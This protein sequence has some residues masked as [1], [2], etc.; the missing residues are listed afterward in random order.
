MLLSF[1]RTVECRTRN[2]GFIASG[3]G[4]GQ[5]GSDDALRAFLQALGLSG[6]LAPLGA[7]RPSHTAAT[8]PLP[9]LHRQFDQIV[10][11]TQ[12]LI[13]KSPDVRKDFWK[14]ADA[15]SIAAWKE[16][17][18]FYRDYIWD[19]VIGRMPPPALPPTPVPG[20]FS[21]SRISRDMK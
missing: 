10:D 4:H 12:A 2:S 7:T 9:R 19:E 15:S 5:P 13:R 11:F 6:R 18:K 1:F 8:I 14:N 20:W 21:M 17:T 3:D 16:S